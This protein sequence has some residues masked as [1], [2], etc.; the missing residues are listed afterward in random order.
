MSG[1]RG[2]VLVVVLI[3]LAA[4][5]LAGTLALQELRLQQRLV[6]AT[7]DHQRA[8]DTADAALESAAADLAA[9]LEV[10]ACDQTGC[11]L[12]ERAALDLHAGRDWR[13][14]DLPWW[15][16]HATETKRGY[17][18]LV[19]GGEHRDPD[20][21]TPE[22]RIFHGIARGHGRRGGTVALHAATWRVAAGTTTPRRLSRRILR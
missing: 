17:Y 13:A 22:T 9:R 5:G 19:H 8:R 7:A 3:L 4:T 2:T 21:G 20:D 18:R 14:G 12:S 16:E 6:S 11:G 15:R 10:G 1:Q